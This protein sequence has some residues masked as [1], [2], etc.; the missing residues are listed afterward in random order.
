MKTAHRT[1]WMFILIPA[2]LAVAGCSRAPQARA[3]P[4]M[5]PADQTAP[6]PSSLLPAPPA[7][8][9]VQSA[10]ADQTVIPD[11]VRKS[12][13]RNAVLEESGRASAKDQAS[14]ALEEALN[15]YQEAK[16][17]RERDDLDGALR[18]LDEAFGLILKIQIPPDSP[19]QREKND[20][21]LLIAQRIQEIYASR[22]RPVPDNHKSIPLVENKWV[23]REIESFRGPERT[24]FE[25][26][27]RRSGFYRP[28]I[29]EQLRT[30][31][32]PEEL[33]WL[34][35]IE[36]WFMPRA[37]SYARALGI[38]QFIGSTGAFYGV[39]RDRFIDERM[40]PYKSTKAAI[41]YLTDLHGMFGEWTTALAAYNC[42]ENFVRRVIA[43]QH[44]DFLDNF[45][46]LFERLPFQTARYVPR[47]IATILIVREP[48]KYGFQLPEPY[49]PLAFDTVTIDRPVKLAALSAALGRDAAELSYLNPELRYEATPDRAYPLRVPAGYADRVPEALAAAPR[50]LTPAEQTL[51]WHVVQSG[52]TLTRIAA[53]Y[54]TTVQILE[55][56]NGMRGGA[57]RPGQRL[58]VPVHG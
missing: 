45:W 58:K 24:F 25:E 42:G 52:E 44:V 6:D 34:P 17:A 46:D 43:T 3:G 12:A 55:K 50:Y 56:L 26:A 2:I 35:L 21:R 15:F 9:P 27:Y 57:L 7:P 51:A 4:E 11:E 41:K 53:R 20:L 23:Q 10:P 36:S 22:R 40:D 13:A 47:F 29:V 19:Y 14:A 33:S 16:Q 5:K 49:P 39:G 1:G 48:R 8:R 38:W 54:G 37:L 30:A 31:G 28:W 32:L 18:A